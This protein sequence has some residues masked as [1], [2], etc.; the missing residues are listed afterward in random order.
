MSWPMFRPMHR[1]IP[2]KA[3]ECRRRDALDA[4]HACPR[5]PARHAHAHA[6]PHAPV[7][8]YT[9]STRRTHL[10]ISPQPQGW[11][12]V[13]FY[14]FLSRGLF[15]CIVALLYFRTPCAPFALVAYCVACLVRCD[16]CARSEPCLQ[17]Y[18][19]VLQTVK[20]TATGVSIIKDLRP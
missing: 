7:D 4:L 3:R 5:A 19:D 2:T 13:P 12:L 20:Q 9:T 1:P 6:R 16:G 17:L 8:A 10:T 11:K 18:R 14:L 15:P